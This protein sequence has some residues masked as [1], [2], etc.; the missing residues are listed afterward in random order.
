MRP[1]TAYAAYRARRSRST[2]PSAFPIVPRW[3]APHPCAM[4]FP[5]RLY[6]AVP[7]WVAPDSWF[8]I[9]IRMDCTSRRPLHDAELAQKLLDSVAFYHA[10]RRWFAHLFLLMPDHAHALLAWPREASM[11]LTI[12]DWKRFHTSHA[13]IAWQDG[14]FD[15]RIRNDSEFVE[16]ATYIWRNPVVKGLCEEPESWP[17][18]IEP[19]R[20]RQSE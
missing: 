12:G 17:W 8:H 14:Y 1:R 5:G 9:R 7:P 15:H 3:H 16:K 4:N 10:R 11:S 2:K 19:W 13:D 6:H 20:K 18:V